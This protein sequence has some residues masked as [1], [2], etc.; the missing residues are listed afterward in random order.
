MGKISIHIS[1]LGT[2][3]MRDIIRVMDSS[4]KYKVD[5][6]VQAVNPVA[7]VGESP[8]LQEMP[9]WSE[10]YFD[11]EVNA[12]NR[13]NAYFDLKKSV[14][15]YLAE[16]KSD[17]LLID[18]GDI[19]IDV[20]FFDKDRKKAATE[21]SVKRGGKRI[22]E[23]Y[24]P[25]VLERLSVLELDAD[26][27]KEKLEAYLDKILEIYPPEK[28]ILFENY[29]VNAYYDSELGGVR[30][31]LEW[32]RE[33]DK[34]NKSFDLAFSYCLEKLPSVPVI[35]FPKTVLGDLHHIWGRYSLHYMEGVY[36]YGFEA[37]EA[38]VSGGAAA[39]VKERLRLLHSKWEKRL[40]VESDLLKWLDLARIDIKNMGEGNDV[41]IKIAEGKR[42]NLYQA[43]WFSHGGNGYVLETYDRQIVLELECVGAGKL[44]IRLQGIDRRTA[45]GTRLPL[46]VD[47]MG[48]VVNG[49]IIFDGI[50]QQWHDKAYYF[51]KE[52]YAGEKFRVE[53][54][55]TR[56]GYS[57]DELTNL[58][59]A[60][61]TC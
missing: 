26:Y 56:H 22:Q 8:L 40:G 60:Y 33:A 13:R 20:C 1:I 57:G 36:R 47:Y 24:L 32:N 39:E 25:K 5:R 19:R 23:Q 35:R 37:M 54:F 28:I 10:K 46:W 27:V 12:F 38:I 14:F 17:Y 21:F 45:D 6:Y 18:M 2:C 48:L 43:Q 52:V 15:D 31:S 51:T 34:F 55:L 11:P 44:L 58:I 30:H 50:K 59:K 7:A 9:D 16:V 49:K 53:I 61:S 41:K 4:G 3:L 29:A 42:C